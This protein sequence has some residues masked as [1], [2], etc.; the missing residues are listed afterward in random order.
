M[1][2]GLLVGVALHLQSKEEPISNWLDSWNKV[3]RWIE[4]GGSNEFPLS[5]FELIEVMFEA[6]YGVG[7]KLLPTM[8]PAYFKKP[9]IEW[10]NA[11]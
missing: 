11:K 4:L 2:I 9:Q 8:L 7:Q 1:V 5:F 10:E 6:V 3:G